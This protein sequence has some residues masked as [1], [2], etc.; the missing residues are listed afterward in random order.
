MIVL[1]LEPTLQW[2]KILVQGPCNITGKEGMGGAALPPHARAAVDSGWR[3]EVRGNNC[4]GFVSKTLVHW[5]SWFPFQQLL[6]LSMGH[7][8]GAGL[9]LCP[10]LQQ[11]PKPVKNGLV[12][13]DYVPYETI[14]YRGCT[15]RRTRPNC[16]QYYARNEAQNQNVIN[17]CK[18]VHTQV[19]LSQL[20]HTSTVCTLWT[21]G[22]CAYYPSQWLCTL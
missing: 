17:V 15:I 2:L 13:R 20:R 1:Q 10:T 12:W 22:Q 16:D 9:S 5:G 7:V 14:L 3:A 19:F 4:R 11:H 21:L 18:N 8:R 6:H